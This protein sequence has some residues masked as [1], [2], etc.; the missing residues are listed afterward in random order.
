MAV[1]PSPQLC[2]LSSRSRSITGAVARDPDELRN[3]LARPGTD[4]LDQDLVECGQGDGH[5]LTR[6]PAQAKQVS[7]GVPLS[8][9][10]WSDPH[11]AHRTSRGQPVVHRPPQRSEFRRQ[12]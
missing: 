4:G 6:H 3:H 9:V 2:T 8:A 11:S 7:D 10:E 5:V 1:Q 12:L